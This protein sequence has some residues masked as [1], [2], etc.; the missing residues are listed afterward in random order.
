MEIQK[1]NT[2]K[3]T[4]TET[5]DKKKSQTKFK[6]T[7][8]KDILTVDRNVPTGKDRE[9]CLWQLKFYKNC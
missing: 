1:L 9:D 3:D 8:K 4:L 6:D 7:L 5:I 2:K